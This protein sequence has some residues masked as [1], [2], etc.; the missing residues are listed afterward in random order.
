MEYSFTVFIY[1]LDLARAE[2]LRAELEALIL[3]RVSD[4][5]LFMGPLLAEPYQAEAQEGDDVQEG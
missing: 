3:E 5:G 1:P 4:K 2:A